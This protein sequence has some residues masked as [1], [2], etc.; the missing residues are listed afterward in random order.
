MA[1][2]KIVLD[3]CLHPNYIKIERGSGKKNW[4]RKREKLPLT[5]GQTIIFGFSGEIYLG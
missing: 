1:M 4:T 5:S 2:N 3:L